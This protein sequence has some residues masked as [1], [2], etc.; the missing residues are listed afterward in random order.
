MCEFFE[1][2]LSPD[3]ARALI[4]DQISETRMMNPANFEEKAISLIGRALY[5][6]FYFGYTSKQWGVH[7]SELPPEIVT[8]LP[9]RYNFNNRYF[10][11]VWEGLPLAGYE[12]W[13]AEMIKSPRIKVSLST[14]FF[15]IKSHIHHSK[16]VVYTGPIDKF[17]G[18][19]CGLLGW[20]TLDFQT[21]TLNCD[22]FQGTSVMNYSDLSTPFTR[23]HE[24]KHLHPERRHKSGITTIMKEF[25]RVG[26]RMD[27]PYYPVNSLEDHKALRNYRA[28]ARAEEKYIFGG[29]LGS[30]QYLD[31][32]M[33]IA[34]ALQVF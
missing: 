31:M 24:F 27:D 25:S 6:A 30:Y 22:D 12:N 23:I 29:R 2:A 20:R 21:E 3:E 16:V 7:P 26:S 17:F 4:A 33:A 13:F 14:D 5:E 34:S 11:D 9:V 18:Y 10:S 15:D 19:K 1:K 32:H 28:L 8:R